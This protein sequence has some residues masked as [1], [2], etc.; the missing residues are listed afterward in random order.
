MIISKLREDEQGTDRQTGQQHQT[1]TK[2]LNFRENESTSITLKSG[3]R[4]WNKKGAR[5]AVLRIPVEQM[6]ESLWSIKVKS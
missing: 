3:V 4:K 5:C 1:D 2:K 6:K